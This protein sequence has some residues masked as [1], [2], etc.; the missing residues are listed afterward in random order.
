MEINA[1]F[2]IILVTVAMTEEAVEVLEIQGAARH[3]NIIGIS[4][5]HR[6]ITDLLRK[7][8]EKNTPIFWC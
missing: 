7:E 2:H 4:K 5:A 1:G 3:N 6:E 8:K